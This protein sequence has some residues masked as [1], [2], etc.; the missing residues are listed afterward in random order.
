M[1][2]VRCQLAGEL[3]QLGGRHGPFAEH[4][5]ATLGSHLI[6]HVRGVSNRLELAHD[7]HEGAVGHAEVGGLAPAGDQPQSGDKEQQ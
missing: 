1:L 6:G 4:R 2:R 7:Q 3:L 5:L